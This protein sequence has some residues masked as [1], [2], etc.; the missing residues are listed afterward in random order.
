MHIR[1]DGRVA[2][3]TGAAQGIGQAIAK[4]LNDAGA[5]VHVADIDAE[6]VHGL[7]AAFGGEGHALD[8]SDRNA[9][10]ALVERIVARQGRLD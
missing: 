7:G 5:A 3:V 4:E 10:H 2:L 9:A 1:F 8:V 6:R